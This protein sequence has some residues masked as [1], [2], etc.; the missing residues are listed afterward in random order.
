MKP[1]MYRIVRLVALLVACTALN[2]CE[3]PRV[4]GSIGISSY[5]GGGYY[6]GGPRVGGSIS[7][8]G[9]IH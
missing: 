3:E 8:G 7:I 1:C 6:G 4:Y 5:G 2:G 9:R